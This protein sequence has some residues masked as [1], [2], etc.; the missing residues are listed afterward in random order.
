LLKAALDEV[1]G[2][3]PDSAFTG[4]STKARITVTTSACWESSRRAGGT[5]EEIRRLITAG[6]AGEQVPKRDLNTGRVNGWC[7]ITT[8]DS[9]GEY[10]F[11]SCLDHTLRTPREKLRNAFLTVV[12]EPGKARSVT[13]ARACLKVVLDLVNKL[14]SEPLKKGIRSSHSGMA[15]ANHGWNL[16]VDM[17]SGESV[18]E[19]FALSM[20]EESPYEGY[21]ERVDT[22]E[23]LFFSST[24]FEEATDHCDH[25]VAAMI[26]DAWMR[27]CGIPD[28]L[29]GIVHT[30]CYK[31][32]TVFFYATGVLEG[33]GRSEPE[34]GSN[35]NSVQLVCGVLMG[36]PLTKVVLHMINVVTRRLGSRMHDP[37]FYQVFINGAAANE[38]FRRGLS[39]RKTPASSPSLGL[40]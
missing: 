15:E 34:L 14:C 26:G 19:L 25:A 6:E 2:S 30:T 33:I 35:I 13:K 3:I 11:W 32:R 5:S 24:D 31:P 38:A 10:I 12:K 1:I 29:R 4:L 39:V 18:K 36:D 17:M 28:I 7:D 8:V 37:E 16:F 27:K 20:R 9:L 40:P 22:F 21:T 23:D